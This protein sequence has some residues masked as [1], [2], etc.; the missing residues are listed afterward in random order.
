MFAEAREV[1][2][3]ITVHDVRRMIDEGEA[4][5]LVDVR[6]PEELAAGVIAY[7]GL[8]TI[9][10]GKLELLAP[11]K[12]DMNERIVVVCQTGIRGILAAHTLVKLGYTNVSNIQCGIEGWAFSDYPIRNS[13]GTFVMK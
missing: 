12:L 13:L 10:R 5:T 11:D 6:D 4:F 2:K 1:I 7:D 9:S 3:Q 8:V